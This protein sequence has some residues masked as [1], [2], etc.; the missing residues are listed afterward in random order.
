MQA[1]RTDDEPR[2][3][4]SLPP[5]GLSDPRGLRSL[6]PSAATLRPE[7]VEVSETHP[8][9]RPAWP[10]RRALAVTTLAAGVVAALVVTW[11]SYAATPTAS[12]PDEVMVVSGRAG[13]KTTPLGTHQRWGGAGMKITLDPSLDRLDPAAKNAVVNAFGAWLS[14]GA[15]LPSLTFDAPKEAGTVAEDGV[16]R[17]L[18]APIKIKGHE[19]DVAAT[20]SY[21]DAATGIIKEVDTVFNSTYA[22]GVL[23]TP[24]AV[25]GVSTATSGAEDDEDPVACKAR[26]DLQNVATH[27]AG[28]VFGLGEDVDD[29]SATMYLRS[30]PCETHK[31][32]PKVD[33]VSVMASLYQEPVKGGADPGGGCGGGAHVA[34][35]RSSGSPAGVLGI[36]LFALG[37]RRLRST[38]LARCR[39]SPYARPSLDGPPRRTHPHGD[40]V[41]R[42]RI[43]GRP[44]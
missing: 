12:L 37:I 19:N 9:P 14:A 8:P 43:V 41:A 28:H 35:T 3:L 6:R 42:P 21:A 1:K 22:F 26:Y 32:V 10:L 29:R 23:D 11:R 36:A 20:I 16:N 40:S 38:N 44:R 33:D 34:S 17:F 4:V 18:Y 30:S 25:K 7:R 27:E 31:R 13:L 15:S 5:R 2:I 39:T 24:R